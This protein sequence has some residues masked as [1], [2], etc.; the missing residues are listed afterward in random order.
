MGDGDGHVGRLHAA[1][2]LDRNGTAVL[3]I[4]GTRGTLAVDVPEDM[5]DPLATTVAELQAVY[6]GDT[7]GTLV[8]E[9][10]DDAA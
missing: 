1:T 8:G 2:V 9:A 5:T 6:D 4:R 3:A 10:P 7:D